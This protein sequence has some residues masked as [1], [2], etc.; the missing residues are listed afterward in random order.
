MMST[1][2]PVPAQADQWGPRATE[3]G[4]TDTIPHFFLTT[5][6]YSS[7]VEAKSAPS[8]RTLGRSS[9]VPGTPETT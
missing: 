8:Q 5:T 7:R 2:D 6:S 1:S 4:S 3:N 9:A